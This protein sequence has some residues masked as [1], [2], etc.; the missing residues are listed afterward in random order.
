MDDFI[1]FK[2]HVHGALINSPHTSC[3]SVQT[4]GQL[5]PHKLGFCGL[6][7]WSIAAI[8]RKIIY[9]FRRYT[10][11]TSSLHYN[12]NIA[13]KWNFSNPDNHLFGLGLLLGAYDKR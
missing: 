8:S 3:E 1:A 13:W 5:E 4:T 12:P 11:V 7:C 9:Q 6:Q 2:S 10:G